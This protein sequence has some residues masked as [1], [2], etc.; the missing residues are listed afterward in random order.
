M[1]LRRQKMSRIYK[2]STQVADLH[3]I[4]FYMHDVVDAC[5]AGRL[6]L[7][8]QGDTGSGKTQLAKDAMGYFGAGI[9]NGDMANQV[10]ERYESTLDPKARLA[11]GATQYF[12]GDKTLFILGRNDM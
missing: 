2:N 11:I 3:G 4:P 5:L 9:G 8:L 7:F 10:R 12:Q 1:L 6:N